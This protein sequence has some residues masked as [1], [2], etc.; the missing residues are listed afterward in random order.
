MVVVKAVSAVVKVTGGDPALFGAVG[1]GFLADKS[2]SAASLKA[3][4]R[5]AN[6]EAQVFA[7]LNRRRANLVGRRRGRVLD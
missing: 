1:D 3:R 7:G 5:R 2:A 6:R 4:S